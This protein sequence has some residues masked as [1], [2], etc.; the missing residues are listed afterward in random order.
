MQNLKLFVTGHKGFETPLLHEL[1][2]ILDSTTAV[3]RKA[4]GGVEIESTI[5]AA[6]RVCLHSRLANR[7]FCELGQASAD[8]ENALYQ[9]VYRI[10]WER[11]LLPRNSIAVSATVSRS[12]L[13][14]SQFVALKTKDA[15]VDRMREIC[16][17]RP[18]VEKNRPDLQLHL[19]LHQNR[20]KI[21]LDLSGESLHRR[22]YRQR[23]AGAPLKE[24][25]AAALLWQAGWRPGQAAYGRLLD[26]MCGAGTF[27]IEAAMIAADIAPGL[28]R[29]YFGFS[30]WLWHDEALWQQCLQ[31]AEQAQKPTREGIV[32]ASDRDAEALAIARA[33]AERAGVAR[34]IDF[35]PK[36]VDALRLPPAAGET[37]IICNPPYGRR[38]GSEAGL[39]RL[40]RELGEAARRHD[41]AR[42]AILSANPELL[43][44][45]KLR[46]VSRKNLRNGPLDC[47]FAQFETAAVDTAVPAPPPL[48]PK[49]DAAALPLRN[50]LLKNARHLGR[51]AKRNDV[52]C[53]RLYDADLPEFAFA[54]DRYQSEID[55]SQ[56]WYSLQEY[57]APASVDSALAAQR[58]EIAAAVVSE[59]FEVASGQLYCKTRSRQRGAEQYRKQDSQ[60]EFFRVREGAASL[61]VN[62][63]DYL[64]SGLFLDHRLTRERVYRQARGKRLL[65]LFCYTGVVGVQAALGGAHSVTNVDLSPTYLDWAK[66]NFRLN[67]LAD[68]N[69]YVFLRADIVE[70][71]KNPSGFAIKAGYDLIFFDPPSFS[72]S[73]KM[74]ETLDIQRDHATMIRQA[75]GLLAADGW[76]LFSTNRRDFR[77][78]PELD[79]EFEVADI[80][81]ATLPEDFRRNPKIHRCWEIKHGP[82]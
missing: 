70:L 10:E 36:P 1:R 31:Q 48:P 50:R 63:S 16:G 13:G 76:M 5:A 47:L 55:A 11:H 53:Y 73:K 62:P 56:V 21:S 12:K 81:R 66:K 40:Y 79:R 59:L 22:G 17:S 61:L 8:S 45:L 15:V 51:W 44:E 20:A 2:L 34:W 25:L 37:L 28:R 23:H 29:E 49:D 60:G 6:Y 19:H 65:N 54:L 27:A 75:M 38:L 32:F 33:N 9:A 42:L 78:D 58:I 3:L 82:A 7:V 68:E 67:G 30:R 39:D 14:H 71:L 43:H 35:S 4:Y 24:H 72:N 64:D 57:R 74:R 46:R 77:L 41:P 69:R 52:T 18:A 26:P 80:S